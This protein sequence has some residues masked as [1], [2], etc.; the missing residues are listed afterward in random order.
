MFERLTEDDVTGALDDLIN[1]LGI[2]QE[3]PC[4]DLVALLEEKDAQRCVEGIAA[5]LG[6]PI[7]IQLSYVSKDF[8]T[9]TTN[10]FDSAALTQTDSGGRGTDSI[11]AQVSVPQDPP[12]FGTP[13][14]QGFPVQIRVSQGCYAHPETFVAIMAHELSHVLLAFLW[15]PQKDSELHTDLVPIVL[16][17]RE[18]VRRGRKTI[19]KR[20]SGNLIITETTTHGYLTDSQFEFACSYVTAKLHCHFEDRKRLLEIV[21]E[22]WTRLAKATRSIAAFRDYYRYLD[23]HLPRTMK[24]EHAERLVQ[25]HGQDQTLDW[26][27]RIAAVRKSVELAETFAKKLDDYQA[28][29]AERLKTELDLVQVASRELDHVTRDIATDERVLRRYVAL[30]HRIQRSLRG[31]L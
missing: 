19:E 9:G 12:M 5:R 16:G 15:F 18:I 23:T 2:K 4:N 29:D 10:S 3:M 28:R 7:R 22:L 8:P 17:F 26:E 30:T 1:C 27:R 11:I 14:L 24:R 6:L 31:W 20:T 21:D 25:L 13:G